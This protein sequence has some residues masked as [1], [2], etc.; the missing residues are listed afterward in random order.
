LLRHQLPSEH[1]LLGCFSESS[2]Y[3]GAGLGYGPQVPQSTSAQLL[4]ALGIQG[5]DLDVDMQL[6]SLLAEVAKPP[7]PPP[8]NITYVI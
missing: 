6:H 7:P 8:E 4:G 1:T 5:L 2:L 3:P